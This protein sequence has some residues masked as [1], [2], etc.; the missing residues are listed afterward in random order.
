MNT[1][2]KTFKSVF[3]FAFFIYFILTSN[4]V[5]AQKSPWQLEVGYGQVYVRPG[6]TDNLAQKEYIWSDDERGD[7]FSMRTSLTHAM[8]LGLRYDIFKWWSVNLDFKQFYR[9]YY[10][11]SGTFIDEPGELDAPGKFEIVPYVNGLDLPDMFLGKTLRSL[12]WQLGTEFSHRLNQNGKWRLHYFLSLNR[13]QYEVDLDA[14]D[15]DVNYG[16]GGH[17]TRLFSQERI[18][19]IM[20]GKFELKSDNPGRSGFQGSTNLGLGLS[21]KLGNGMGLRFE[22][23]YRNILWTKNLQLDENHWELNLNYK[24]F[25]ESIEDITYETSTAYEFPLEVA[26]L[27]TNIAFTFRPFR[28]KR[29]R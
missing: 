12:S 3:T 21:R 5:G 29:D 26:G 22:M 18:D 20:E 2:I 28:S 9:R 24:E 1:S 23:G 10:V 14:F 27:Y 6:T 15:T 25:D 17:Y 7:L 11:W 8:D 4:Y 16:G 19:Y 13:D